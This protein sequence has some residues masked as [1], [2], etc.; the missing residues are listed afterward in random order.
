MPVVLSH[1][2]LA[3]A[4]TAIKNNPN[5]EQIKIEFLEVVK[6]IVKLTIEKFPVQCMDDMRQEIQIFLMKRADYIANAFF[7]GKIENPTNYLFRVCYNSAMNFFKREAKH[8]VHLVPIDDV[9]VD[10]VYRASNAEKQKILIK[11]REQ[12]MDF[13]RVRFTLKS[14]QKKAEKFL[15][16]LL[17]GK[18]PSFH[19]V[20]L[21]KFSRGNQK[22]AKDIY[23]IVLMEIRELVKPHI[24][25]L[26]EN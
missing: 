26:T 22:D 1:E 16:A 25:E 15:A 10:P 12:M 11:I 14:D 23:S 18:R 20:P 8:A 9:K 19:T 2:E 17:D 3:K 7:S 5:N 24:S 21:E 13:I 4:L 6:P